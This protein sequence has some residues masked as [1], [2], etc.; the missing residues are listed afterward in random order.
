MKFEMCKRVEKNPK[1]HVSE[2]R[3]AV[4]IKCAKKYDRNPDLWSPVMENVGDYYS[5]DK[6]LLRARHKVI[7]NAPKNRK[8]IDENEDIIVLDSNCLPWKVLI[9]IT[10]QKAHML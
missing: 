6:R 10:L 8:I 9:F 1:K 2:A 5:V 3:N 4:M 7:G